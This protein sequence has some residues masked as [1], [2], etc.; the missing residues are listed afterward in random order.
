MSFKP[1]FNLKHTG[2]VYS[3]YGSTYFRVLQRSFR[4]APNWNASLKQCWQ[5]ASG[6]I[7]Q[8]HA[9]MAANVCIVGHHHLRGE[10]SIGQGS[11]TYRATMF[12]LSFR[13]S[14]GLL[15]DFLLWEILGGARKWHHQLGRGTKCCAVFKL[16]QR[17]ESVICSMCDWS[18]NGVF[19]QHFMVWYRMKW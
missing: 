18:G 13:I 5:K 16:G 14:F 15:V 8:K 10:T 1:S 6:W 12:F 7:S 3:P 4:T 2:L 17:A 19:S 11:L 9:Q